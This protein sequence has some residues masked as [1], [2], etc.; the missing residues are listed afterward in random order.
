MQPPQL[1][2]NPWL[3]RWQQRTFNHQKE[4]LDATDSSRPIFITGKKNKQTNQSLVKKSENCL[5]TERKEKL[6]TSEAFFFSRDENLS[7]T[8]QSGAAFFLLH[9]APRTLLPN[10]NCSLWKGLKRGVTPFFIA[11][12]L[13][14]TN[15][16]HTDMALSKSGAQLMLA[17]YLILILNPIFS[18][19]TY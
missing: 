18:W 7:R 10:E 11:N 13:S 6:A 14:H 3:F 12:L 19:R 9:D 5:A 17:R 16:L 2:S 8:D 15:L 1:G 4:A